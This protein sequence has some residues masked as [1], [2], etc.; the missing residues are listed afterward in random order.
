MR[1]KLRYF[2]T[3]KKKNQLNT[4]KMVMQ[5]TMDKNALDIQITNSKITEF[6]SFL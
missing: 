3:K 6:K 5:E 4:K 2:S 1:N